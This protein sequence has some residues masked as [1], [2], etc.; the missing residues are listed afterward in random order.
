MMDRED[1]TEADYTENGLIRTVILTREGDKYRSELSLFDNERSGINT[2][3]RFSVQGDICAMFGI[4]EYFEPDGED[5]FGHYSV[6]NRI[7][8]YLAV[9][10]IGLI[11]EIEFESEG[12]TFFAYAHQRAPLDRLIEHLEVIPVS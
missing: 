4:Y 11:K 5:F 12:G 10:D 8:R 2:P 1:N 3:R 9:K 7:I 6:E